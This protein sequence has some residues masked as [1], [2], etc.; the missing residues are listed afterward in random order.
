MIIVLYLAATA[1]L[2][3]LVSLLGASFLRQRTPEARRLLDVVDGNR[4]E[5]P[6]E[7]GGEQWKERLLGLAKR[8]RDKLGLGENEKLKAR[9][10]TAGLRDRST[11]DVFFAAQFLLPLGMAFGAS[12]APENTIFL[13]LIGGVLGFIAPDFWLSRKIEQRKT[14]IRRSMP[15]AMDLLVICVDAGL[16]MDQALLRV[17]DELALSHPEINQEFTQVN[18]AQRAGQPRLEAW[19]TLADRTAI[20]EFRQFVNMLTQTERFGTPIAKALSRFSE[21]LRTKRRQYAEQQAAKTKIKIIFP[22]VLC[23]FP[24]IFI[25]LLAPAILTISS[26]ITGMN[27]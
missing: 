22:L 12:F 16:G 15:D 17:G 6:K 7:F 23:I 24:C 19:R 21:D 5:V 26:G 10:M 20:D 18:L 2:F 27:Q 9:L 4:V 1:T 8:L 25:I 3:C 11:G 13:V 14:K